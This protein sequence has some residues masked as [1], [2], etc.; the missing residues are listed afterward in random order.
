MSFRSVPKS[1]TLNDLERRNVVI[2][3]YFSEFVE[4]PGALHKSQRSLSHLLMSSCTNGRP[5]TRDQQ[6]L[7]WATIWPQF[8]Y[9]P[10][11]EGMLCRFPVGRRAA[12]VPI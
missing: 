12:W 7:R 11:S 8:G 1:V 6:L 10:K 9:G 2:L 5:K 3:H 4:L